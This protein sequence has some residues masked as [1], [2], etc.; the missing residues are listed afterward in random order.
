MACTHTQPLDLFK[1]AQEHLTKKNIP[2]ADWEG[3]Q[4][5]FTENLNSDLHKSV[6]MEVQRKNNQW[7][8]TQIDR[9]PTIAEEKDLGVKLFDE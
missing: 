7:V 9:R 4:M 3:F 2:E 1:M 6:Y 5:G 8:C